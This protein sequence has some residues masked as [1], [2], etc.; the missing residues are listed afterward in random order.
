MPER[1]QNRFFSTVRPQTRSTF[2]QSRKSA[3]PNPVPSLEHQ[4]QRQQM[5]ELKNQL[6]VRKLQELYQVSCN[7]NL[8]ITFTK[9]TWEKFHQLKSKT[10]E[11]KGVVQ[12]YGEFIKDLKFVIYLGAAAQMIQLDQKKAIYLGG[13]GINYKRQVV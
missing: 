8:D 12:A 7:E 11:K 1:L 6:H 5:E 9:D 3:Q 13:L 10:D 4:E 2:T